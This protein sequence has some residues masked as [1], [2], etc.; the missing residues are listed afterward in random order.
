MQYVFS[1]TFSKLKEVSSPSYG[2]YIDYPLTLSYDICIHISANL[3]AS[4]KLDSLSKGN[5]PYS[6]GSYEAKT[7]VLN[8]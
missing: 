2:F 4:Y 6:A 3:V 8:A 5:L 7:R 1:F